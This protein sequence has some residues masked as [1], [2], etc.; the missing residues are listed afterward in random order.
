MHHA[1]PTLPTIPTIF[2]PDLP[3]RVGIINVIKGEAGSISRADVAAF[4]LDAVQKPD[5]AYLR[6][7][8][9]ISSDKGTSWVKEKGMTIG[10]K[11]VV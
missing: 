7:A 11:E 8:P 4:C 6:S 2:S 3:A 1:G 5:F 9:C 10:G